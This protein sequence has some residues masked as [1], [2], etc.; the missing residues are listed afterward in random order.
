VSTIGWL[1]AE[2]RTTQVMESTTFLALGIDAG[3]THTRA[4]AMAGDVIVYDGIGGPGNP[5]TASDAQLARSYQDAL[6]G[7]PEPTAIAVCAAGTG[8]EEGRAKIERVVRTRFPDAEIEVAPDYVAALMAADSDVDVIVVAGTG[9]IVCSRPRG[10]VHC[11]GGHGWLLGD[12][13]SG[14][15]LGRE[16]LE[17]FCATGAD[18]PLVADIELVFSVSTPG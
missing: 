18:T 10:N 7:C 1:A 2:D 5:L 15:R 9:S 3:G 14:A 17:R 6:D 4:R 12:H 8:A 16:A 11:D 13:G